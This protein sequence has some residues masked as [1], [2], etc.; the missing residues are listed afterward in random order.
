MDQ[1][2]KHEAGAAVPRV[3]KAASE[4]AFRVWVG[5]LAQSAE[6]LMRAA[7]PPAEEEGA[8]RDGHH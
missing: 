1:I 4:A 5:S 8:D 2:R 6:A 7:S 3:S